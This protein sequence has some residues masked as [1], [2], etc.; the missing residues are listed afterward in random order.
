MFLSWCH[1][2]Q[3]LILEV[4]NGKTPEACR[5]EPAA[6]EGTRG[7]S[8]HQCSKWGFSEALSPVQYDM[9][10]L[11]LLS[12]LQSITKSYLPT[13]ASVSIRTSAACKSHCEVSGSHRP[14][15]SSLS[16]RIQHGDLRVAD[17]WC[18]PGHRHA[19]SLHQDQL[20]VST[21][22]SMSFLREEWAVEL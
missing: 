13:V 20:S 18:I 4:K 6:P 19:T 15:E 10:Q 9:S 7:V 2:K 5:W 21:H 22:I 16:F 14:P 8:F 17:S 1:W 11:L 12:V 3:R